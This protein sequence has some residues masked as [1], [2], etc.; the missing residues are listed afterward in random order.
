VGRLV[1]G[2]AMWMVTWLVESS[3][4][5]MDSRSGT[6]SEREWERPSETEWAKSS[7]LSLA[8]RSGTVSVRRSHKRKTR[9][10]MSVSHFQMQRSPQQVA[11]L[12]YLQRCPPHLV[13]R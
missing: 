1:P 6:D 9:F 12:Q 3:G 13:I 4:T 7:A 10:H 11:W 2:S 5:V 8:T